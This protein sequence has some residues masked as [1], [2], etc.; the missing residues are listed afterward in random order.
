M[1]RKSIGSFLA[2]LRKSNGMTQQEVADRL[3][4]SNKTVSKWE[5]DESYPEITLIPVLAELF[6]V[7]SDEILRGERMTKNENTSDKKD[8]KVEKQ[9]NLIIDSSITRFKSFSYVTMALPLFGLICLFTIAYSFYKPVL[10]FGVFLYFIVS[11]IMVELIQMNIQ[12]KISIRNKDL[13]QDVSLLKPLHKNKI[14]YSAI[15]FA[16]NITAVI[17]ALPIILVRSPYFVNSVITMESYLSLVPVLTVLIGIVLKIVYQVAVHK[18]KSY[19]EDHVDNTFPKS[20][21]T[22]MNLLHLGFILLMLYGM[23]SGTFRTTAVYPRK[24]I[25][26]IALTFIIA[27]TIGFSVTGK[28]RRDRLLFAVAGV[29]NLL[30]GIVGMIMSLWLYFTLSDRRDSISFGFPSAFLLIFVLGVALL[31]DVIKKKLYEQ[32]NQK[33]V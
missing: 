33:A 32:V 11:S 26:L 10:A 7:T 15:V 19:D 8:V 21:M 31:Y 22:N 5:R 29:R 18:I 20:R 23:L 2:A 1:E 4:V 25:I 27:S 13:F 24:E 28:V 9:I 3:S 30:I 6:S 17:I 12:E 14:K 16:S